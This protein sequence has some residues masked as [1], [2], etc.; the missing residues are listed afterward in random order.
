MNAGCYGGETWRYVAQV[1]VL[2][3]AG[4]FERRLPSDYVIGYRSVRRADTKSP[5]GLFT[6]AWFAFPS[7]DGQHARD[8]I[9]QLLQKRIATQPLDLPNAGSVFRNPPDDHAARLIESCGTQRLRG[10]RCA[11]LG[12]A[13]QLHRQSGCPGNCGRHRSVDRACAQN[14]A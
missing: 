11:H 12:Q 3:P 7:G 1:E 8:R 5:E 10:W 14:G 13:R 9:K 6:A 4:V 2:T